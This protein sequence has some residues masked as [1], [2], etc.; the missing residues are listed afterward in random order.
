MSLHLFKVLFVS[1]FFTGCVVKSPSNPEDEM[2]QLAA[3][4]QALGEHV[5]KEESMQLSKDIFY[6]TQI[7]TKAFDRTSP[8]LWHNFLVNTGLREKGLCYHWADALY[9]YLS[10]KNYTSFEFHLVG[11]DIGNYFLEH[12][13]LVVVSKGGKIEEGVIVDPWR[14]ATEVYFSKVKEDSA[15]LWKHRVDRGCR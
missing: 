6:Q 13:A 10:K 3:L 12:N 4:L 11:A 15:Y 9:L 14:N 8:P 2:R 7:L 1:L 5:S